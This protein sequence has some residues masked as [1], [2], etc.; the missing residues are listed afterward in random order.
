MASELDMINQN[1]PR[2]SPDQVHYI[3][4]ATLNLASILEKLRVLTQKDPGCGSVWK[5]QVPV[6]KD[7]QFVSS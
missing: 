4:Q 5:S 2:L 1:S 7:F 6:S 3:T